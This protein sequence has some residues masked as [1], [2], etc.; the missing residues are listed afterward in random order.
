MSSDQHGRSAGARVG[1]IGGTFDPLHYGHLAAA[2]AAAGALGLDRVLFVPSRHPPHRPDTPAASGYHRLAMTALGVG[3]VPGWQTSEVE[4]AREGKSY[5]FDTLAELRRAEP[6]S[7]FF[8]I[9]G[10]DAFA[11]I[12]TW[13]RYPDVL[14]LAHFVVIARPGTTLDQLRARL[15]DLA[16]RMVSLPVPR[17]VIASAASGPPVIFLVNT[18]TPDISGSEIRRRAARGEPL[19]GLVPEPVARYIAT[20]HLYRGDEE[21]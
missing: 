4:L 5:T 13:W 7:Q 11:E 8:F 18:D 9:T 6:A 17:D 12:A 1:V 19:D 14:D 2:R 15:P 10:A 3:G 21:K 16:T 20:H